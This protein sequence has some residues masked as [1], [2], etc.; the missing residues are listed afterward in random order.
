MLFLLELLPA[1]CLGLLLGRRWPGLPARLAPPL[2]HWGVP[3]SVMGLLLR[4]GL[5]WRF[6]QV[7]LLALLAVAAGL[8]LVSFWLRSPVERLGAV[9]GNTAYF[10]I[11]AVLALLPAEAVGYAISYDLAATLFTWTLGP[12]L[13]AGQPLRLRPLLR[14]L[15][16]SPAS[17][18]LLAA[19]LLQLT[20]WHGVLAAW[21]WWPARA[22]VLVSLM[23]VGMR[24]AWVAGRALSAR[25]WAVLLCKLLLFPL[26]VLGAAQLLAL[27]PLALPPL[28]QAALVLQAAAPTAVSVLLLSELSPAQ[29]PAAAEPAV[30]AALL[31]WCTLLGLLT[32]PLW[33]KL[34]APLAS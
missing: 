17:R 10:G 2:V 23:V 8:L 16:S 4:G 1:L 15:T 19:A 26:L 9:V 31:L 11:P 18:G 29:D 13:L 20:P 30:A 6:G 7:A 25:L 33:A 27:T 21:L 22:V 5:N 32:V 12:L 28:A 3:F 34:L 24:L 14:A